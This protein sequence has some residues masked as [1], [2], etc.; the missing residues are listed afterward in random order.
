MSYE[1]HLDL[2]HK[3]RLL[4][5]AAADPELT[6]TSLRLLI[7]LVDYFAGPNGCYPSL[8]QM[9][10]FFGCSRTTIT[11][12]IAQLIARKYL[13]VDRSRG[14]C[15][16]R[17]RYFFARFTRIPT[18]PKTVQP[19]GPLKGEKTVQP[20]GPQWSNGLDPNGPAQAT[21]NNPYLNNP[22]EESLLPYPTDTAAS[23]DGEHVVRESSEDDLNSVIWTEGISFLQTLSLDLDDKPM[24]ERRARQLLGMWQR[25]HGGE[26]VL[27]AL[28]D[29]ST[30][31][32][33][34]VVAHIEYVLSTGDFHEPA[35][36]IIPPSQTVDCFKTID[37]QAE[38]EAKPEAKAER[39]EW[40][41]RW[42]KTYAELRDQLSECTEPA[43]REQLEARIEIA[44]NHAGIAPDTVDV[45][46][47]ES[48]RKRVATKRV[49]RKEAANERGGG[50]D[51]AEDVM[52][53]PRSAW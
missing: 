21:G 51:D 39:K 5:V 48:A 36:E 31:C 30:E 17:N 18:P 47:S 37:A 14:G 38:K 32:G 4:L 35:V 7:V 42:K 12:A 6:Q 13:R 49:R 43:E 34:G 33:G 1:A 16:K 27:A 28:N 9:Q 19:A 26:A 22:T 3:M 10:E 53:G 23:P 25:D 40:A 45:R 52:L 15:N 2:V 20:A 41:D 50:H 8:R 11:S 24:S 44:R 29:A 46:L